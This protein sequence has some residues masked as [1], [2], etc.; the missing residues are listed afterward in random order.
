METINYTFAECVDLLPVA[1]KYCMDSFERSV[2]NQLQGA[3]TLPEYVELMVA[4]Q[5]ISSADMHIRALDGLILNWRSMSLDQAQRI[6][7]D[8]LF[9]VA[10]RYTARC[11]QC[12][13]SNPGYLRCQACG[14]TG[15]IR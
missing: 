13:T 15:H 6:G 4:S 9:N 8:A 5:L 3:S 7:V 14:H 10:N 12:N 11:Y 1:H 2:I